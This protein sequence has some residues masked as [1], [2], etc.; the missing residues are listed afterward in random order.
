MSDRRCDLA[1][2]ELVERTGDCRIADPGVPLAG[3]MVY[4]RSDAADY[5]KRMDAALT[6]SRN[7]SER[8]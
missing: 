1:E 5:R 3:V 7:L 2:A 6:A 4:E 8:M